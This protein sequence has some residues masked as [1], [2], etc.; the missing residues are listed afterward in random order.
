V[1]GDRARWE[2]ALERTGLGGRARDMASHLSGGEKQ[3]L[4][5]ARAIYK[6]ATVI[7]VDEPTASLDA[8]NRRPVIDLLAGLADMGRTVIVATHDDEM[9]AACG[10][11]HAVGATSVAELNEVAAR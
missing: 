4:A 1:T 5:V 9:M 10:V 8:D 11:L 6:D 2:S 7:L 3:R